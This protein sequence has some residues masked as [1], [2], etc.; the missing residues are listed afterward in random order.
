MRDV[1]K[2]WQ[3][4]RMLV[5]VAI[6][7]AVYVA[8]R[9]P[10]AAFQLVPGLTEFRPGAA[11]PV[12]FSFLFGPAAAWGS[13]FGNLVADVLG[14]EFGPG[15]AFGFVGNFLYAYIPYK[16]WFALVRRREP[17]PKSIGSWVALV[18]VMVTA[19]LACAVSISWGADMIKLVP[20]GV[21]VNIIALNNII[22]SVVLST[23]LLFLVYPRVAKWGMVYWEIMDPEDIGEP[24]FPRLG[25]LLV[26]VA[27]I[28]GFAIGN[29]AAF[30]I[31]TQIFA[32]IS[33]PVVLLP[34][35]ILL[36]VGCLFI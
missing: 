32:G 9:L 19:S 31:G 30:G 29:A 15:S 5:L 16:L 14:A 28:A 11:V 7:A 24:R 35:I 4:T 17:L 8:V 3:N 18:A 1:F 33:L 27:V 26:I 13:A 20:F 23:I 6:C 25:A 12:L 22:A 34:L 2:M 36:L 21:L 10:F